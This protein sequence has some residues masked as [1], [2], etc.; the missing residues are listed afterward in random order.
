MTTNKKYTL[1]DDTMLHHGHTL[2]RIKAV[3]DF[4]NVHVGDLG[5]WVEDESNLSQ[6]GDCWIYDDAKVYANA[7]VG[8]DAFLSTNAE[9][10]D[11]ARILGSARILHNA[12][13]YGAAVIS[14][15]VWIRNS[16]Q[17]Y[18]HACIHGNVNLWDNV[19][20]YGTTCLSGDLAVWDK[21][22]IN[23]IGKE[24]L[25]L[26]GDFSIHGNA[27]INAMSDIMIF[28][29]WWSSGRYFIWTRS[30]NMWTVGC[31]YGNGKG[32]IKKAYKDSDKSGYWYKEAVDY[33][34][35]ID[36]IDY[37][38]KSKKSLFRRLLSKIFH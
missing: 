3:K 26:N 19:K 22:I 37:S 11:K 10:Y 4:A 24:Y 38:K 30:N 28:K 29:N 18:G 12:E 25:V 36:K 35:R 32:L 34:G 9:A 7:W 1:T 13:V 33:V 8:G 6:R 16:V 14:G 20:V 27:I 17:V 21:V 15:D 5:G 2:Y 23:G 31:F